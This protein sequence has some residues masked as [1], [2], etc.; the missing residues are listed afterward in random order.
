MD[1]AVRNCS[2][3]RWRFV[4]TSA[5]EFIR[6]IHLGVERLHSEARALSICDWSHIETPSLRP[7]LCD[8][9]QQYTRPKPGEETLSRQSL[10][11]AH[12]KIT[13][14]SWE[15][16]FATPATRF[17]TDYS[18]DKAPKKDPLKQ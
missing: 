12:K 1:P 18:F 7:K 2:R 9:S 13:E 6:C 8:C 15:P 16:T 17:G 14:L 3:A 10:S 11:K 5:L 4:D